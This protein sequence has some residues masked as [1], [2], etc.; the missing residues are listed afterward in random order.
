MASWTFD[1]PAVTFDNR[2]V[3]F[4]GT[5]KFSAALAGA[6]ADIDFAAGA[7]TTSLGGPLPPVLVPRLGYLVP[8]PGL[9]V[10]P[11]GPEMGYLTPL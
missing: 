4:D 11:A 1:N 6:P 9:S 8:L 2:F 10:T 7:L 3:Y 5:R